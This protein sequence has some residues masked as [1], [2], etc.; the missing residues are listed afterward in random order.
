MY[1]IDWG[2]LG[3]R[4]VV[5]R[6]TLK[7]KS[8]RA[9]AMA[10]DAD[11]SYFGRAEKGSSLSDNYIDKIV[12]LFNVNKE[13]LLYGNGEMF[14]PSNSDKNF[15]ANRR[16]QKTIPIERTLDYYNVGA[17]ASLKTEGEILP[18][19]KP[20][21]KL[22]ISELFQGS[23]FAIR[24]SGNSMTPNYPSGCIIGIRLIEDFAVNPGSVYVIESSNDLWIKRVYYKDDNRESETLELVSDNNLKHESGPRKGKY[25]YPPFHLH[26]SEI[27]NIFRV[28]GVFKSNTLT[29]IEN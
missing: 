3:K 17:N 26:K 4:L 20:V 15:I 12:D 6:A 10:I 9:F 18:A 25:C 1:K 8:S 11:P 21:G 28:T 13:W 5:L 7:I 14:N 16:N 2:E 19:S 29:I 23:Q 27:K 24:V 22:M